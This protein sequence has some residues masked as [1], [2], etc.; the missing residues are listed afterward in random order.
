MRDVQVEYGKEVL[1]VS[2]AVARE[3]AETGLAVWVP[4]RRNRMVWTARRD[5]RP[6][7][8]GL[9]CRVGEWPDG[10]LAGAFLGDVFR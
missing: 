8:R 9:S 10:Q 3:W 4:S 7:I 2:G 6:V 5:P 1:C